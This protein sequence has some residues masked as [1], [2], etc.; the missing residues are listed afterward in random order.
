VFPSHHGGF[1]G[2]DSAYPG[3]PEEFARTLRDVVDD[4][5]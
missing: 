5:S 2:G 4:K 3:K 1:I